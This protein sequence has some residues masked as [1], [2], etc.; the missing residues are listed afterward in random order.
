[1][2]QEPQKEVQPEEIPELEKQP[3]K[4]PIQKAIIPSPEGSEQKAFNPISEIYP[5]QIIVD[6]SLY[7]AIWNNKGALLRSWKLKKHK[8]DNEEYL[9]IISSLSE[10]TDKYPFLIYSDD[11]SFNTYVNSSLFSASKTKLIL[12]RGE[13]KEL[14]FQFADERGNKVEK[15]FN[16]T[17]GKYE[18]DIQ[19]NVWKNGQKIEPTIL[20]GPSICN[21]SPKAQKQRYGG[22]KG[23]AVYSANKVFRQNEKKFKPSK[24]TFNF[25]DWAAYETN[26]F[27]ALFIT[28]PEKTSAAFIREEKNKIPYFYLSISYPKK[29]YIGPKSIDFLNEVGYE[30]KKIINFGFFGFVAEILLVAMKY[31]HSCIPNWGF[32]IIIMTFIIKILV[33]PLTYKSTL[34]MAKMQGIQPK[35]KALRTKYKKAKQDMQQRKKMNEEMM[36]LYKEH[37]INPA[38]GCLPLLIQLP[39]FWGFFRLLVVSVEFRQSPFIF[40]LKDLSLKDPLYITP[41]LMGITQFISQK[42]T[43][44]GAEPAQQKMMLIMPFIMTIL[45]MNFQSGLVLY[46]LT[47]NV[48][49]IGQQYIINNLMKKKKRETHGKKRRKK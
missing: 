17:D 3:Q 10:D 14:R 18:V 1:M 15:I 13:S 42:M 38:G 36:K 29:V 33:F 26:Y 5:K 4:E 21:P 19:I 41:I 8:N 30:S 39:I 2:K 20:W 34:S 48:L 40:W 16:F 31:I 22:T 23:I 25:V 46:W 47:N 7:Q 45:L 24:S 49:Q 12:K 35:I 27:T 44:T 32:C 9:E 43:P 37:G 28:S 11:P 6:T